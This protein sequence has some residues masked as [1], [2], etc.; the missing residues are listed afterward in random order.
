MAGTRAS[1]DLPDLHG[2]IRPVLIIAENKYPSRL[3]K[4]KIGLKETLIL[5]RLIVFHRERPTQIL[6]GFNQ[7]EEYS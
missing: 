5:K 6:L 2:H 4:A 7:G 3:T 1:P